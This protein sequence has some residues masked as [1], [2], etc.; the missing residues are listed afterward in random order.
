MVTGGA[1]GIGKLMGE[2]CL[3]KGARR[4][5]I[6]DVNEQALAS[7]SKEFKEKGYQ[8]HAYKVDVSDP[9]DVESAAYTIQE[10]IGSVDLLINN[11]GI[12]IGKHF[13][14]HTH[15]DIRRTVDINVSGVM[16]V[17]LAFLDE[18]LFRG[19]GHIVNISSAS[20]FTPNPKMSVY[21]GSKWAVLGWSESLRLEMERENTG[22]KVTT[23]TP[24]Y[25]DTGMFDGVSAPFLTPI[26]T[27][28]KI[29]DQIMNA[30]EEDEILLRSPYIVNYLPLLRG[31]LPTR[32]FDKLADAFGVYESMSGFKGHIS[33]KGPEVTPARKQVEAK[34]K[35][36]DKGSE[37]AS[38]KEESPEP[39]KA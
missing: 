11:A 25:I 8:V 27:P 30:V 18:M 16:Y 6:W 12:V 14:E 34:A 38:Q 15:E 3:K 33:K 19:K 29:V 20:G 39:A 9:K 1:A 17:A 21:A 24:G 10:D 31:V 37:K 7:T 2:E 26:L 36:E 35:K 23:V 4:L 32:I 28:K 13:N 5:I 22:V